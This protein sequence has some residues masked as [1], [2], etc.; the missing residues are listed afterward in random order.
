[1]SASQGRMITILIQS[2]F[3]FVSSSELN[4]AGPAV[5]TSCGNW[6]AD[7]SVFIY[8]P[9]LVDVYMYEKAFWVGLR[10]NTDGISVARV[11]LQFSVPGQ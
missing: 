9:L 8:D 1:M 5:P 7:R 3:F 10:V 6:P 2:V 11:S 4:G